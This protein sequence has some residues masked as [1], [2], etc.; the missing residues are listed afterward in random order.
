[1]MY[2]LMKIGRILIFII[3]CRTTDFR[4][5]YQYI[6]YNKLSQRSFHSGYRFYYWMY[7][8]TITNDQIKQIYY[9]QNNHD[10]QLVQDLYVQS[11]YPSIKEEIVNNKIH[12]LTTQ[13]VNISITKVNK[14]YNTKRA[15]KIKVEFVVNDPMNYGIDNGTLIHF[16]HLL[17]VVL[18]TDWS[19][20]CTAFSK[21]FRSEKRFE[22]ILS[23]K[24]RNRE[25]ANWARLIRE[26]VEYFGNDGWWEG[27]PDEYKS[28]EYDHYYET[29]PFFCGMSFLMVIPQFNIRLTGP[30]ST[31]KEIE[32][33][34]T[35]SG[36]YGIII[37]LNNNGCW[38]SQ[39]LMSWNCCWMSNYSG[40]NERIWCGGFIQIKVEN[41]M[42]VS[43]NE[44]FHD[45]FKSLYHFDCMISGNQMINFT[46]TTVKNTDYL[47]LSNLINHR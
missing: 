22:T 12:C 33:A 14:Y 43:T 19:D 20:L 26:T 34:E 7:Y 4:M 3:I 10:G 41:I 31:T 47:T 15:K 39:S 28:K 18:Y 37:Q 13:Q 35:F 1:M 38:G 42:I 17:S 8:K 9:N 24:Y 36:D 23:V 46:D 32:V 44:S 5:V 2:F 16:D 6:Y 29:G 25:Y 21:T 11:K 30:T 40:E 27:Y 45:F